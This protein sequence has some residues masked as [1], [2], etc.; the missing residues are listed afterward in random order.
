MEF[1]RALPEY[2]DTD[3]KIHILDPGNFRETTVGPDFQ[4]HAER[5]FPSFFND[6][7][8]LAGG[9]RYVLNMFLPTA[10][11]IGL[12]LHIVEGSEVRHSFGV[13]ISETAPPLNQFNTRRVLATDRSDHVFSAPYYEYLIEV[14]SATGRRVTGFQGPL[15]N[16]NPPLPGPF[17]DDNPPPSQV[18]A[19][20]A[21]A[22]SRLWVVSLQVRDNWRSRMAEVVLPNGEVRL[23][24]LDESP[25][26]LYWAR[27]DLIDLNTAT[28]VASSDRDELITAFVGDRLGLEVQYLEDGTPR[29]V[30]WSIGLTNANGR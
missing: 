24:Q 7:A 12:P 4:L 9:E 11:H 20:Q 10:D 6:A 8:R 13:Q 15:L 16:E 17:G 1:G 21:D 22:G 27:I 19:L 30:V 25:R 14:W 29:L 23:R 18:W 3:G 5:R 2:T 26:S 28:I